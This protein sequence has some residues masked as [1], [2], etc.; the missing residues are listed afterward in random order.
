MPSAPPPLE[1]SPRGPW[2]QLHQ[3]AQDGL[4]ELALALLSSGWID[5]D[6]GTQ[7]GWTPLMYATIEGCLLVVRILLDNGAKTNLVADGGVDA[8]STAAM[9]GHLGVVKALL[10][11]GANLEGA[12]TSLSTTALHVAVAHGH[13]EVVNELIEAGANP[14]T[15]RP[16]DGGTALALGVVGRIRGHCQA[17]PTCESGPVIG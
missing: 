5:I 14:N 16:R 17:S 6:Q 15:R 9:G 3:A 12:N 8:L 1:H 4:V 2:N 10:A 7:G 13:T 11:A